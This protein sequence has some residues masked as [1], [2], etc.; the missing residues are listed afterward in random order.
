MCYC[1][2]VLLSIW[3]LETHKTVVTDL[4]HY[5]NYKTGFGDRKVS[6]CDPKVVSCIFEELLRSLKPM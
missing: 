2:V 5:Y 4:L 3:L 1:N 6:A